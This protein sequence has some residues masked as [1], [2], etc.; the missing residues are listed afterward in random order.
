MI[1]YT[2]PL[3]SGPLTALPFH[4]VPCHTQI[5]GTTNTRATFKEIAKIYIYLGSQVP[6]Y[7]LTKVNDIKL[8]NPEFQLETLMNNIN[9][10]LVTDK[11]KQL[12]LK[13]IHNAIY[14]ADWAIKYQSV[15]L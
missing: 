9:T 6:D 1:D 11:T 14:V 8:I 12:V 10:L 4:T 3:K 13:A 15:T 7:L 2:I 5:A